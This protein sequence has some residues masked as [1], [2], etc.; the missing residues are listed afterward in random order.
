VL[1]ELKNVP[2]TMVKALFAS[3]PERVARVLQEKGGKTK[4]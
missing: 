4:Y 1:R 2:Q 3:M